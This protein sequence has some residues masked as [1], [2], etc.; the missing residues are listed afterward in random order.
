MGLS[1]GLWRFLLHGTRVFAYGVTMTYN[2]EEEAEE[3]EEELGHGYR[4][5]L[6]VCLVSIKQPW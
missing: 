2:D 6:S 5:W 4:C 3:V 1:E